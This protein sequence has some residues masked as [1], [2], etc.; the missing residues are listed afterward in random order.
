MFEV[1]D[2]SASILPARKIVRSGASLTVH[3]AI[4]PHQDKLTGVDE[5]RFMLPHNGAGAGLVPV[6]FKGGA[7]YRL[8]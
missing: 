1:M 2:P 7:Q 6:A 8:A 3:F 5:I 4:G